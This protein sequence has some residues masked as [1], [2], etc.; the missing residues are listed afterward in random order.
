MII[1]IRIIVM[2]WTIFWTISILILVNYVITTW[3]Y[4]GRAPMFCL[5]FWINSTALKV[6]NSDHLYL[7]RK[8]AACYL[9]YHYNFYHSRKMEICMV[10]L[11]L[12][13]QPY[14][15]SLKTQNCIIKSQMEFLKWQ[16]RHLQYTYMYHRKAS[17]WDLLLNNILKLLHIC[18]YRILHLLL[19]MVVES[20]V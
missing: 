1:S 18:N 12:V 4:F 2:K 7:L 20:T 17:S 5:I 9:T 15:K 6:R 3:I 8:I 19:N 11:D 10:C 16:S 13:H 14:R